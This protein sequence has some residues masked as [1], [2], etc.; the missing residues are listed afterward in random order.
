MK[1]ILRHITDYYTDVLHTKPP[2]LPTDELP[3]LSGIAKE[4]STQDIVKLL[5]LI[6]ALAVK[7]SKNATYVQTIQTFPPERQSTLMYLLQT[8]LKSTTCIDVRYYLTRRPVYR[9]MGSSSPSS[10]ACTNDSDDAQLRFEEELAKVSAERDTIEKAHL[11]LMDEH[12]ELRLKAV[13]WLRSVN[14]IR[15]NCRKLLK[16]QRLGRGKLKKQLDHWVIKQILIYA[17]NSIGYNLN[18]ISAF[19]LSYV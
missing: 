5:R 3:N 18:C 19:P 2:T 1:K 12:N 13:S 9:R 7:S 15:I 17:Q 4:K 10:L 14:D 11:T 6:L 8:V 16:K